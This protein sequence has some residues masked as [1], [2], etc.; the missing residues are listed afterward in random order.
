MTV[1]IARSLL[2]RIRTH[3]ATQT[4][5]ICGLLLGGADRIDAIMP[6]AN[7]APDPSRH[8]ELDPAVLIGAHRAA[9]QGGPAIVGHYHSHPSGVAVPSAVDA[10]SAAPDDSI[11]MIVASDGVRLW[12]AGPGEGGV[13]FREARLVVE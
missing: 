10:A 12:R 11:W 3:A 5:E 13:V 6:A 4:T 1:R 7:V 2:E 8:F 9:R